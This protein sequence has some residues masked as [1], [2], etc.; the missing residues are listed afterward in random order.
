M[1]AALDAEIVRIQTDGVTADELQIAQAQERVGE[2]GSLQTALG[3]ASRL[4][5]YAV[6]FH[7][8][9]RVNTL[10]PRLQAVSAADVQRV[11]KKYL[12]PANRSVVITLPATTAP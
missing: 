4:G 6:L 9:N 12:V 7:D 3:R 2:I 1:E 10:L 11:A 8:P 5:L